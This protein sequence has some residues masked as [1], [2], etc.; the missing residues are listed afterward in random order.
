MNEFGS[1]DE[2]FDLVSEKYHN[3]VEKNKKIL[4]NE[5]NDKTSIGLSEFGAK[6]QTYV[7]RDNEGNPVGVLGIKRM[8]SVRNVQA[9]GLGGAWQFSIF[10]DESNAGKEHGGS[11][12]DK[13]PEIVASKIRE[14]DG[15][16][17]GHFTVIEFIKA[18][19]GD[20]SNDAMKQMLQ[21]RGY[22]LNGSAYQKQLTKIG[23]YLY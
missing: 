19:E 17:D 22:V 11:M 5:E 1:K 7:Y 23:T 14:K 9:T 8:S 6:G 15:L 16:N 21:T 20:P 2:S 4:S 3:W 10:V 18:P 13:A 12:L